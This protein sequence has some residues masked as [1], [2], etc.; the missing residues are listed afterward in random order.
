[1][2]ETSSKDTKYI[3]SFDINEQLMMMVQQMHTVKE[4]MPTYLGWHLMNVTW[5][6]KWSQTHELK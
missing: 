1:M 6:D 2:N 3:L 5:P 4:S